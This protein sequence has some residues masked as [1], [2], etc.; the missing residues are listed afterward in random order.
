MEPWKRRMRVMG[1]AIIGSVLAA[2]AAYGIVM[3]R[4]GWRG[5]VAADM[6][7]A[8]AAVRETFGID[9]ADDGAGGASDDEQR[10]R[11]HERWHWA[12][13]HPFA[14]S[15]PSRLVQPCSQRSAQDQEVAIRCGQAASVAY[16]RSQI[17]CLAE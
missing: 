12:A 5:S 1:I 9:A 17:V 3:M 6:H 10:Y 14:P 2:A 16:P 13:E 7:A 11:Q 4:G 8:A 15:P